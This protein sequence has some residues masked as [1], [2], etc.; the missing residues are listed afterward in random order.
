MPLHF[1]NI[2]F[3]H[4]IQK[5]IRP[6]VQP[7]TVYLHGVK[8]ISIL[9]LNAVEHPFKKIFFFPPF[10]FWKLGLWQES[11]L[12]YFYSYVLQIKT[13]Q[14]IFFKSK[15]GS[16]IKI[17]QIPCLLN[18]FGDIELKII[19]STYWVTNRSLSHW[20]AIFM[21]L[22]FKGGAFL[23]LSS[24]VGIKGN[25]NKTC[26]STLVLL[27]TVS[28]TRAVKCQSKFS[29]AKTGPFQASGLYPI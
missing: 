25:P 19:I 21:L 14:K 5:K 23:W 7:D 10:H 13:K 24:R 20:G 9:T 8:F 16:E 17:L 11:E 1:I 3:K 22:N 29:F 28:H 12:I 2:I 15:K 6:C 27:F 26:A 18:C 4:D